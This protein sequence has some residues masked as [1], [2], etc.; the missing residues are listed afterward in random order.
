LSG[1]S[2]QPVAEAEVLALGRDVGR[3]WWLWLVTGIAWVIASLIILQFDK[4]SVTTV[5]IIVGCMF[6]A[7]GAQQLTIAF[8]TDRLRWLWAIFG[9]LFIICGIVAFIHPQ[10]TFAALAD[11]LGFLFLVVGV[12]WTIEAFVQRQENELWWLG[13]ISGILMVILA[14]WT[15]GQFFFHRV[16]TLLIISGIWALMHGVMDIVHAFQVKKLQDM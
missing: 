15:S 7:A 4:A 12:W 8:I 9:V 16:Y 1:T 13:L 10:G 11:T 3:Y 2:S 6:L 5:G 14:F